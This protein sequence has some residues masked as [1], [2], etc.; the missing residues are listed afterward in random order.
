MATLAGEIFNRPASVTVIIV[1]WNSGVLLD[2]CVAQLAEQ[3]LKPDHILIID[4]ASTDGSVD[5]IPAIPG[6]TIQKLVKNIGFAAANN[7]ALSVCNTEFLALLN[8]D[9]FPEPAWLEQLLAAA[10]TYP[11]V[12]AF[13]SKQLIYGSDD[14]IDGIGDVYHCSGLVWRRGHRCPQSD[15]EELPHEIFSPCACAALYRREALQTVGGFDEDYFCY[16]EDIDLGFRL[17]LAGYK[18]MYVP[19]AV[20][21]H[22]GSATTGGRHSD[23]SIYYGHRNLVW[24]YVKNMPGILFWL[25]L[26]FHIL[27]NAVSVI[28]F[29]GLG[30]GKIIARA[31][32]D[33]IQGVSKMWKKRRDI[34]QYRK[35]SIREIWRILDKNLFLLR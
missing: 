21:R 28:Y 11:D 20:V 34:P 2:R 13:G 1:N 31:K 12:S 5:F 23:F 32:W 25:F 35:A 16:A 4:N 30:K 10:K 15:F 27:L 8:P 18:A 29:S 26:P 14:L 7:L 9:A 17:R 6:V 3:S 22:V 19:S 33:A 24:A